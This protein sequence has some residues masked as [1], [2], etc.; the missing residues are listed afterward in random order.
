[1]NL[2][3]ILSYALTYFDIFG[4]VLSGILGGM[5]ARE[6]RFDIVGFCALAFMVALGGGM[7]RDVL[8]QAGPPVALTNPYYIR[9]AFVGAVIAYI[10]PLRGKWWNRFAIVSDAFVVGCWAPTGAIKTLNAGYDIPPAIL[11][12]VLTAVGGGMI[13]DVAIGRKPAVFG[14]NTLYAT[15]AI[16]ATVPA[17]VLWNYRM[18]TLGLVLGMMVGGLLCIAARWFKWRLPVN[19][20]Y[21][22]ASHVRRSYEGYRARRCSDLEATPRRPAIRLVRKNRK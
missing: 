9:G 13:R 15:G 22:I 21:S 14:G 10:L 5:A 11:L 2:N 3:E 7:V 1:M 18:P 12:G 4:V 6:E 16:A 8:L 20:D 19:N 17:I